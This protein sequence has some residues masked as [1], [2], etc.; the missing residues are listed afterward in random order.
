[1]S[2]GRAFRIRV[3]LRP[4]F[5][6][7]TALLYCLAMA[8]AA[9]SL[10]EQERRA[11]TSE[12]IQRGEAVADGLASAAR[13]ALLT[14]D[15]VSCM[16][17]ARG[18][19]GSAGGAGASGHDFSR[20]SDWFEGMAR[21]W[22]EI[23]IWT[24]HASGEAGAPGHGI[25]EAVLVDRDG[26]VAAE[27]RDTRRIGQT[28][29]PPK[30]LREAGDGA[31]YPLCRVERPGL[32]T[33]QEYLVDRAV[34]VRTP[35]GLDKSL[36]RV[37]IGVD[38]DGVDAAV[39]ASA[40]KLADVA[41]AAMAL[42]AFFAYLLVSVL[43]APLGRLANGVSAVSAGEFRSRIRVSGRDELGELSAAFNA[44]AES[45]S[46]NERL[47]GA[48]T[49][50]VSG[51]ALTRILADPGLGGGLRSR[52]VEATILCSDV[53]GFTAMCGTLEPEEA[54]QV[55]NTYL[56]LQTEIILKHGGQVDL[57]VGDAVVAVW[58]KENPDPEDAARAV[59]AALE[60]QRRIAALNAVRAAE[61]GIVK[62]VGIGLDSGEVVAGNLGTSRK[63]EYTVT[64]ERVL[65][66]EELCGECPGG[67][68]RIGRGTYERVKDRFRVEAVL[69]PGRGQ[70]TR[71]WKVLE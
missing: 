58:G 42:G 21:A 34:V 68:V 50:Y 6:L 52:R 16:T 23:G 11:F 59:G 29:V 66:A 2:A 14:G 46:Q 25:V 12:A 5:V 70:E 1:M 37:Y 63:M 60:I 41:L 13:E 49:R 15:A 19:V 32:G 69:E 53:R 40:M 7:A 67:E 45:L 17:L 36:G 44:M 71:S 47:K 35:D 61:G 48:F 18:A 54:V 10:F 30:A 38:K 51:A 27:D 9:Y 31:P 39:F 62:Q 8:A 55:V 24:L 22:V 3:G 33:V 57:F 26:R 56:S 65:A 28:Y 43:T 20:P 4:K 64:G